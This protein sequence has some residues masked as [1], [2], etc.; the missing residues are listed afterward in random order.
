MEAE[1]RATVCMELETGEAPG[2]RAPLAAELAYA[3]ADPFAVTMT[4]HCEGGEVTRWRLDRQLL[5]DGC[6]GPAGEGDVRVEPT[7][8]GGRGK[9]VRI[10][11][12]GMPGPAGRAHGV[13]HVAAGDVTAF[14]AATRDVVVPGEERICLDEL[15]AACFGELGDSETPFGEHAA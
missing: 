10:E 2:G 13:L 8:E 12:F 6:R 3:A 11:L 1:V 14:L 15:V 5:T 4:F 7:L 9:G